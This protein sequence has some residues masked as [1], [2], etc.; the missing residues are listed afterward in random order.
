MH[1][2][3]YPRYIHLNE[4]KREVFILELKHN[5]TSKEGMKQIIDNNYAAK[6]ILARDVVFSISINYN[7]VAK[8]I[9]SI[10]YIIN[11]KKYT[12]IEKYFKVYI[13]EENLLIKSIFTELKFRK[14]DTDE[15]SND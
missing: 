9:N 6:Y 5:R 11:K 4:N 14:G 2:D 15:N 3:T 12:E 7:Q 8:T 13:S 1:S 10:A